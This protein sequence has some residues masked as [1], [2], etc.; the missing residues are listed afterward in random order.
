MLG[1]SSVEPLSRIARM[2]NVLVV[3]SYKF[4]VIHYKTKRELLV[5]TVLDQPRA[6]H[7]QKALRRLTIAP[8]LLLISQC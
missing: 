8:A 7:T 5:W 2:E 3:L 4:V 1:F 6:S